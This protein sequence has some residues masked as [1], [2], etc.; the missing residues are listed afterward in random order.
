MR[1]LIASPRHGPLSVRVANDDGPALR[2]GAR[3]RLLVALVP[4]DDLE[5]EVEVARFALFCCVCERINE[6]I[7]ISRNLP[8]TLQVEV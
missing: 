5:G 7:Q 4:D 2:L 1:L 3:R 6:M 8:T